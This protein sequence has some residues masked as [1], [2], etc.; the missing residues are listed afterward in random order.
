MNL[1]FIKRKIADVPDIPKTGIMIR[2]ITHL[3]ADPQG[4]R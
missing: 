1:D 4:L 3:L 2:D